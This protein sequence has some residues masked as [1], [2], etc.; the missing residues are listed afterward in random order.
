MMDQYNGPLGPFNFKKITVVS[1]G[2]RREGDGVEGMSA[3]RMREY[4][5]T[6]NYSAFIKGLPPTTEDHAR[7]LYDE[8]RK[9]LGL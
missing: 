8:V 9:G 3:T 4:A 2:D 5:E 1:A 6:G 7:E